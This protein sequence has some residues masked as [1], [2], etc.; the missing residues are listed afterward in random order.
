MTIFQQIILNAVNS[1]WK[2]AKLS[3]EQKF[4]KSVCKL[5]KN[6]FLC[7]YFQRSIQNP[8]KYIRWSVLQ[9]QLKPLF[10]QSVPSY[11]F[12][13]IFIIITCSNLFLVNLMS[14]RNL[15]IHFYRKLVDW[16][17]YDVSFYWKKVL[18]TLNFWLLTIFLSTHTVLIHRNVSN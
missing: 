12:I 6:H 3:M 10:S 13:K 1:T 18:E 16:F 7:R 14:L 9:K 8:V 2:K 17:M 15:S 11:M 5:A 4:S